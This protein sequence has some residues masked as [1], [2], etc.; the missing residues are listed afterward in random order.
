VFLAFLALLAPVYAQDCTATFDQVMGLAERS[1]VAWED[2]SSGSF[3]DTT[4]DLQAALPCLSG[5]L[6]PPEIVTLYLV[7]LLDHWWRNERSDAYQAWTSIRTLEPDFDLTVEVAL[8]D[9]GLIAWI[10]GQDEQPGAEPA[11]P[12]PVVP[13]S[14]WRVEGHDGARVVPVGRPVIVQLMDTRDGHLQTWFL[15]EGGLPEGFES[16]KGQGA[17][18]WLDRSDD[19][20]RAS[21]ESA[22]SRETKPEDAA[23]RREITALDDALQVQA[24]RGTARHGV[25]LLAVGGGC[26][27]AGAAAAGITYGLGVSQRPV[28][29]DSAVWL[30]FINFTAWGLA[31]SGGAVAGLGGVRWLGQGP[32]RHR[33]QLVVGPTGGVLVGTW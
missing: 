33:L 8:V 23:A 6:E 25:P 5:L 28:S 26:L 17:R 12:L 7:D 31:I 1:I 9:P 21:Q 30:E 27:V 13:W 10:N 22:T 32:G 14:L 19:R 16:A 3:L 4:K 29:H 15:S 20:A 11:I 2:N 24:S 18:G